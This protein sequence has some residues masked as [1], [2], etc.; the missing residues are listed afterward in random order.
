MI[1]VKIAIVVLLF[2]SK[3]ALAQIVTKTDPYY[4][5]MNNVQITSKTRDEILADE[6]GAEVKVLVKM[7]AGKSITQILT[8]KVDA[9][10]ESMNIFALQVNKDDLH[11]LENDPNVEYVEIDHTVRAVAEE[12]IVHKQQG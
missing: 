10:I 1:K 2:A 9:I 4:T 8:S 7:L 6:T 5:S 11:A 12:P 3:N